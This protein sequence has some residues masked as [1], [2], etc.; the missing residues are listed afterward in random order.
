M[1]DY[2]HVAAQYK[3]FKES[4]FCR[5]AEEP[6]YFRHIGDLSGEAVL[7]LA[8]GEGH[9]TRRIKA[10][11]AARVV[12]VD[13]SEG[14]IALARD[15]ERQHPLG[16]EYLVGDGAGLG[17]LGSFDRVT[18]SY[19]LN[20]A[21]DRPALV[22]MCRTA[23]ENL[24]PGGRFVTLI[25]NGDLTPEPGGP[26]SKLKKYNFYFVS[27]ASPC[28]DGTPVTGYVGADDAFTVTMYHYAWA[29]Y[30]AALEEAGFRGVRCEPLAVT[31][32]G[33]AAMPEGYWDD[34][35]AL[36][37]L[38]CAEASRPAAPA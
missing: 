24:R 23:Y 16:V 13:L 7:D 25:P 2:D 26:T 36:A 4:P 12:G 34:F 6:T 33:V 20:Y 29:T 1:A 30:R 14:M 15:Q 32:E 22:R 3:R 38:V 10:R 27:Q 5:Y 18:A 17:K 9:Y 28:T 31:P 19:L 35:L 37:P 8:C 21:P 11:G